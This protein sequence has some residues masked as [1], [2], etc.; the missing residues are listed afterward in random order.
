M[1]YAREVGSK[2]KYFRFLGEYHTS[3]IEPKTIISTTKTL[4]LM[5]SSKLTILY[6]KP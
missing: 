6:L 2:K 4:T 3:L 1:T 5:P